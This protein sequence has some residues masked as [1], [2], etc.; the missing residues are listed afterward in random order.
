MLLSVADVRPRCAYDSCQKK[1]GGPTISRQPH[2]EIRHRIPQSDPIAA[3]GALSGK[4]LRAMRGAGARFSH[5]ALVQVRAPLA[6]H[7]PFFRSFG[8]R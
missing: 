3:R 2:E 8:A 5:V 6:A 4:G 7:P 1:G